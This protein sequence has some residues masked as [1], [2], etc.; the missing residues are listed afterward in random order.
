MK[1]LKKHTSGT[2]AVTERNLAAKAGHLE[3]LG[4]GKRDKKKEMAAAAAAAAKGGVK[5]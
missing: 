4:G 1:M 2:T 5:K 3:L